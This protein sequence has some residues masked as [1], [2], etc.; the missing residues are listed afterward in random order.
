MATTDEFPR[1]VSGLDPAEPPQVIELNSGDHFNLRVAPVAKRIGTQ[2]RGCSPTTA[3]S[4]ATR[5]VPEGAE[6]DVTVENQGD[7]ET[8]VHWHGLRLDWRSD[9]THET[10]API[11]V[12]GTY[13]CRVAFPDPGAYWYHPLRPRGLCPGARSLTPASRSGRSRTRCAAPRSPHASSSLR[14]ASTRS[15]AGCIPVAT[16]RSAAAT[17]WPPRPSCRAHRGPTRTRRPPRRRTEDAS[18]AGPWSP[19]RRHEPGASAAAHHRCRAAA[20]PGS[21]ATDPPRRTSFQGLPS[22]AV[23]R[24]IPRM[25]ARRCQRPRAEPDPRCTA[26]SRQARGA[27]SRRS[28]GPARHRQDAAPAPAAPHPTH[29]SRR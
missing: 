26:F 29:I 28:S 9:G 15:P 20:R 2:P 22:R 7:L 4:R 12:G 19:R 13:S 11:E 23:L 1:Y 6:I 21:A 10:Q 25:R 5:K 3:P 17:T 24:A 27:P 14:N 8:T 18:T 16:A